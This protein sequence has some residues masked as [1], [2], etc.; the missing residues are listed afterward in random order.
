MKKIQLVAL[1]L[2]VLSLLI[3]PA[4]AQE[5]R[6]LDEPVKNLQF[7]EK[8]T[9][10]ALF[11][12][13]D[14]VTVIKRSHTYHLTRLDNRFTGAVIARE[15]VKQS[16][17]DEL[18][19]SM[20]KRRKEERERLT[21]SAVKAST[22]PHVPDA[23]PDELRVL[24]PSIVPIEQTDADW[25]KDA[26]VLKVK[27]TVAPARIVST[28]SMIQEKQR[29]FDEIGEMRSLAVAALA[30]I[31]Q[32]Q[33]RDVGSGEP[34]LPN[35]DYLDTVNR[36]AA[37]DWYERARHY[38]LVGR[39]GEAIGAYTQAVETMP[40]LAVAYRNRG[41]LYLS[42]MKDKVKAASDFNSAIQAYS[43][44]AASHMKSGEYQKCIDAIE[45]A[46]SLHAKFAK[47]YYQRA[48][49]RTGLGKRDGIREDFIRAAQLGDKSAQD[50]LSAR[51]IAW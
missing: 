49:C 14:D 17:I 3:L 29:V 19:D 2:G 22:A 7:K 28:V 31:R 37:A 44:N 36:L 8:L 12:E 4:H 35:Q 45:A 10:D 46:L 15:R 24:L 9:E 42:H 39:T 1:C 43:S 41:R 48:A 23:N 13:G 16:I 5:P 20:G 50:L 32:M 40:G 6:H 18:I 11:S 34:A 26:L 25:G 30:E 38:E 33:E 21:K 51:G 27:A 47:G